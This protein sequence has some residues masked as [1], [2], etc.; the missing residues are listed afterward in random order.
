M[1]LYSV[2]KLCL[3]PGTEWLVNGNTTK[4]DGVCPSIAPGYGLVYCNF[5]LYLQRRINAREMTTIP[6]TA[7][8][9]IPPTGEQSF[10]VQAGGPG[11]GAVVMEV[12]PL[13]LVESNVDDVIKVELVT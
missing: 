12:V 8:P 11:S 2:E 3:D 13:V 9:T 1:P 7:P 4:C 5:C 10:P 6:A